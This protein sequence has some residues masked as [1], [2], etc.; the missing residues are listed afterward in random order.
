M[1]LAM[2][3]ASARHHIR[4]SP[5]SESSNS[6][7]H[8]PEVQRAL[9]GG[10]V[11]CSSRNGK[12]GVGSLTNLG[13]NLPFLIMCVISFARMDGGR[14]IEE[15]MRM[16]RPTRRTDGLMIRERGVGESERG[17]CAM[18][19]KL[20]FAPFYTMTLLLTRHSPAGPEGRRMLEQACRSSARMTIR[21]WGQLARD[22][23][24]GNRRRF[25]SSHSS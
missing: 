12:A 9:T 16:R 15:E 1:L 8:L 7:S 25:P 18:G 2:S 22:F 3:D 19:G 6:R 17:K 13:E 4:F 14:P 11:F 23:C 24:S 5:F 21:R 20:N 10:Q